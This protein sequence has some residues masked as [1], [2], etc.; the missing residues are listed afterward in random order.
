M[1]DLPVVNAIE[2][3]S[4]QDVENRETLQRSFRASLGAL[5]TKIRAQTNILSSISDTL[6]AAYDIQQQ[7]VQ[8]GDES[9]DLGNTDTLQRSFRASIGALGTKIRAQTEVMREIADTVQAA[10]NIDQ[11]QLIQDAEDR[12]EEARKKAEEEEQ[13]RREGSLV[14]KVKGGLLTTLKNAFLGGALIGTVMLVKDNW[15]AITNA[16][17]KIKPTLITIKDKIMEV[18]D[19]AVPF[20]LDN[21]DIIAKSLAATWLALK[22]WAGIKLMADAVR[23]IKAGFLAV[24]AATLAAGTRMSQ[25]AATMRAS[26]LGTGL[27]AA[28]GGITAGV[29]AFKAAILAAGAAIAPILVAAAPIVAIAAGIALVLFGVKKAFDEARAVFAET[30]SVSMAITEGLSKLFA[31]IVGFVPDLLKSATSW[32]L[33]KLGFDEAAEALDSF[34]ITDF[35]QNG[36]SNIFS[37]MRILF[38][39]A[40]NG[41]VSVVNGLLDFIPGFGPNT[42][43]P[44]FNI[45]QEE[46]KIAEANRLRDERQ[47]EKLEG[48]SAANAKEII[49]GMGTESGGSVGTE[50][51]AQ[52]AQAAVA[53][54]NVTVT[55]VSPTNINA[56]NLTNVSS[57][58]NVTPTATRSRSRFRSRGRNAYA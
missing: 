45:A 36:I 3:Q 56:P 25:L 2:A 41:I 20:L 16:F 34:S 52:S 47:K 6:I 29:V 27:V 24:Q 9:V 50:I 12:L 58:T 46:F 49:E 55:T 38:M 40:V 10:Y 23:A 37:R 42:I 8:G 5:G 19:V 39:K 33:G 15:D 48:E 11:Q 21:F 28:W 30:G 17:E 1:A 43:D 51:N 4:E 14:G 13:K 22:V 53:G 18:A 32:I 7:Q 57:Q 44:V 26:A 35:I 31:T 54:G